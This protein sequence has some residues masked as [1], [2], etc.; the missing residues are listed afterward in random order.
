MVKKVVLYGTKTCPW[1]DKAE[2]FLKENN[3]KFEKKNVGEDSAARSEM[4]DKSGQLGVPVIDVEGTIIVGFDRE[5]LKK[6]LGLKA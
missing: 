1:C 3:V 6:S 5:K 4:L 2:A